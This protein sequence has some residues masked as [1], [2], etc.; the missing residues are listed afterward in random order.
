MSR[1]VVALRTSTCLPIAAAADFH[2]CDCR[3]TGRTAGSDKQRKAHRS[4]QE[5]VQEPQPLTHNA[6]C[7]VSDTGRIAPRLVEASDQPC[8]DRVHACA[9]D[10]RNGRGQ[11]FDHACGVRA[12]GSGDDCNATSDQIGGQFRQ[13]IAL[14]VGPAIFDRDVTALDE[15]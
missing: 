12:G 1:L 15:A 8:L 7:H 13:P 2:L 10:D 14:I 11:A 6:H 9:E 3:L 5:F 4:R